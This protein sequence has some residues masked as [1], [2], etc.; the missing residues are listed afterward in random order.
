MNNSPSLPF[1]LLFIVGS[2]VFLVLIY[3]FAV[4]QWEAKVAEP[5]LRRIGRPYYAL[6]LLTFAA[7]GTA[8]TIEQA[9]GSPFAEALV[10]LFGGLFILALGWPIL[11]QWKSQTMSPAR[12]LLA[13]GLAALIILIALASFVVAY[14]DLRILAK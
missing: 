13:A 10:P 1:Q 14:N 12:R 9:T 11:V 2:A 6:I 5:R 4:R 3:K 8:R 7:G